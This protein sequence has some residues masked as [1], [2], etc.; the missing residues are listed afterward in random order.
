MRVNLWCLLGVLVVAAPL[1]IV[2]DIAST[3]DTKDFFKSVLRAMCCCS[4][5]YFASEHTNEDKGTVAEDCTVY[6]H[7]T[8][9]DST[10]EES[11]VH[12]VCVCL[13]ACVCACMRVYVHVLGIMKHS[14]TD[15]PIFLHMTKACT[16]TNNDLFL[17][18]QLQLPLIAVMLLRTRIAC[19][20][21]TSL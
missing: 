14:S 18:S 10:N 6:T 19:R 20:S 12:G 2:T 5:L 15:P 11:P 17:P 9:E 13:H 3:S 4:G 21:N 16:G 1:Y 8:V 7:T